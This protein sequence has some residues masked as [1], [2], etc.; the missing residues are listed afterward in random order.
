MRGEVDKIHAEG[1]ELAFIGNGA[2]HFARAFKD[3]FHVESPLFTDPSLAAYQAAELKA[4]LGSPLRLAKNGW[5]AFRA[6]FRQVDTQG[7]AFQLGG[8]LVIDR[9]GQVL[10]HFASREAGDHP[11]ISDIHA[12]LAAAKG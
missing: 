9:D 10:F 8:V 3:E 4:Q 6:G 5:R 11:P 2:P 7:D 12:A 1:G